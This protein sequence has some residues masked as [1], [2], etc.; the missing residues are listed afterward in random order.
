MTTKLS[1]FLSLEFFFNQNSIKQEENHEEDSSAI[2]SWI[3]E[4][5][6]HNK[7][8]AELKEGE[9]HLRGKSASMFYRGRQQIED[10]YASFKHDLSAYESIF[11]SSKNRLKEFGKAQHGLVKDL[12]KIASPNTTFEQVRSAILKYKDQANE[13]RTENSIAAHFHEPSDHFLGNYE[14]PFLSD[15][16]SFITTQHLEKGMSA[17]VP[18]LTEENKDKIVGLAFEIQKLQIE[19]ADLDESIGMCVDHTDSPIRGFVDEIYEDHEIMAVLNPFSEHGMTE[20]DHNAGLVDILVQR[21][22]N[23]YEALWTYIRRSCH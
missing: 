6:E 11:K 17:E 12:D 15:D 18:G 21:V 13:F 9:V 14:T 8:D 5:T 22:D 3:N 4:H 1:N 19:L 10:V 2:Y 20:E 7:L 16:K 23:L